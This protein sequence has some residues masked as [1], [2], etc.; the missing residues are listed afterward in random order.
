MPLSKLLD[1]AL[2]NNP[3]TRASWNAARAAA[4]GFHASLSYYYP[5]ITYS[6]DLTTQ[7]TNGSAVA[8]SGGGAVIDSGGNPVTLDGTSNANVSAT[9]STTLFDDITASYLLFDF[10]GRDAQAQAALFLLEQANWQHNLTMQQVMLAVINNYTA[11][12]GNKALVIAGEQDL[13]DAETALEAAVKMREAGLSTLTDVLSAQSS[14]EQMRLNLEQ[15]RGAE[16]TAFA[17]LLITLGLPAD[18]Q[19]SVV[20]LPEKLPVVEISGNISALI[21]LAKERRPDIGAAISAVK[22]QEALLGV[23]YSAGLPVLTVNASSTRLRFL[24][25]SISTIRDQS[26]SLQWSYPVFQGYYYV[27]EQKQIQAQI[28]EALAIVDV[29]VS[30]VS[31]D[32]VVNYY[33][34]KTSEAALPSSESLLQY[35]Q[36]AYRGMLGQ[37]KVGTSS[38]I[39][40]LNA[41]TTLSNAR[42]Q[43]ALNKV[44]WASALANLAFSV[45][46]LEETAGGWQESPPKRLYNIKYKDNKNKDNKS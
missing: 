30:Q 34:F 19:L 45:G 27:N 31:S 4:F 21:A 46:V 10:G 32:V 14:V 44:Q 26:L 40:V 33:A 9:N 25:P 37:Y 28:Q 43:E 20:E 16:K 8:G 1:I 24:R 35:S 3:S 17:Q 39:D 42:A 2:Y 15:A 12:L 36:R 5:F 29:T 23:A 7:K 22:E 13:K 18:T 6:G 38:I 11:Y 41:L